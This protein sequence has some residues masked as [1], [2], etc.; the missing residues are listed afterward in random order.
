MD[1]FCG[2]VI[3]SARAQFGP[4]AF[5]CQNG[6]T[7]NHSVR[8]VSGVPMLSDMDRFRSTN[9][10]AGSMRFRGQPAENRF[11]ENFL[12]DREESCPT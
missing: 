1:H 11:P 12:P 8:L 3:E 2:H 7:G 5:A 9:E 10:Q 4:L 6:L